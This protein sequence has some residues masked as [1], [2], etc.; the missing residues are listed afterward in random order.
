MSGFLD[1][2][3]VGVR[4]LTEHV[5]RFELVSADPARALPPFT[6]GAHVIVTLPSGLERQYSLC[7]DPVDAGRYVIAV[8][9]EDAGRGGSR[10]MH[11]ALAEGTQVRIRA[12]ANQFPLDDGAS[13]ALLLAGGIGITPILSMRRVL[14]RLGRPYRLIYLVRN[15]GEAAFV[16]ELADDLASGMAQLHVDDEAGGFFP[17][18]DVLAAVK[19]GTHVYCCGP[20]PLMREVER[21]G[22]CAGI[23]P[24]ALHFEWF[25]NAEQ[26]TARDRPFQV[27]LAQS[28]LSFEV[29]VGRSILD[30]VLEAGIDADYSCGEGTCGTCV[31]RLLEGEA[32]HRDTVLTAGERETHVAICRSRA[33][34]A[35]LTIDL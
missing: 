19:D 2:R 30:V 9:R 1:L 25:T 29:P 31:V 10:E 20:T 33:R 6:A 7:N 4:D 16:D 15:R 12:P 17:V 21:A 18:A 8:K 23:P 27:T 34:G 13:E 3:V 26:P 14:A 11:L 5:R 24:A 32:D 22:G 28:G 35:G